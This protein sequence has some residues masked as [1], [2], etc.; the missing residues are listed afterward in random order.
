LK[1][2]RECF[3]ALPLAYEAKTNRNFDVVL[4]CLCDQ[5]SVFTDKDMSKY[6]A[7]P[8]P[9]LEETALFSKA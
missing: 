8:Y 5:D 3:F 6:S 1:E 9:P 2:N 7:N 4:H